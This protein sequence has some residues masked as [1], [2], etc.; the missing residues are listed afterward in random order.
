M[1]RC[2]ACESSWIVV[3][4]PLKGIVSC[5]SCRKQWTRT[6]VVRASAGS[7]GTAAFGTPSAQPEKAALPTA[8]DAS[9]P[10]PIAND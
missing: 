5:V 6:A 10:H 7:N 1:L 8:Y 3:G 9:L 2:P 4:Y